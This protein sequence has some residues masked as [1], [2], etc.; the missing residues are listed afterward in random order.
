MSDVL[1]NFIDGKWVESKSGDTFERTNPATGEL[2]ATYTKSGAEDIDLA[3]AAA[4]KAF[5]FWRLTR[6]RSA[7]RF[8][9][10]PRSFW[11][12][13]RSNSRAR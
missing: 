7:A 5:K 11:S 9:T 10:R 8:S 2:V 1:R 12:T 6:R 4:S 3:V 13:R